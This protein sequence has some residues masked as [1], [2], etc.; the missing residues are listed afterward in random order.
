[1][2]AIRAYSNLIY[3]SEV[4]RGLVEAHYRLVTEKVKLVS[5]MA[6]SDQL[7]A[8]AVTTF[9]LNLAVYITFEEHK[10][11]GESPDRALTIIEELV[12]ILSSITLP[13]QQASEPMYRGMVALGTVLAAIHSEELK[14]AAKEI[15]DVPALLKQLEKRGLMKETRFQVVV[16]DTKKA[17]V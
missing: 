7:L 8:I 12:R 6:A 16:A 10:D 14:L 9:Y 13:D 3:A 2:V 4:G 15:F 5:S 11:Q 17:L 1:M